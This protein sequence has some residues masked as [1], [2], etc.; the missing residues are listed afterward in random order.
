MIFQCDIVPIHS[1]HYQILFP[2]RNSFEAMR[3]LF[4]YSI[5]RG[6][7]CAAKMDVNPSFQK[8]L[9]MFTVKCSVVVGKYF[10]GGPCSK[11]MVF[12]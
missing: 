7:I 8:L 3:T 5:A 2:C 10:N 4:N 6:D 1:L 9:E 11:N 12:K